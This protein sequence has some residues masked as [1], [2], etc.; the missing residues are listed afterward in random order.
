M[1]GKKS[2]SSSKAAGMGLPW[3]LEFLSSLDVGAWMFTVLLAFLDMPAF[4]LH[5]HAKGKR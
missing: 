1:Q 5:F 3:N 4:K 2:S